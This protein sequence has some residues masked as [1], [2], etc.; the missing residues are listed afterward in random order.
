MSKPMRAKVVC[1]EVKVFEGSENVTFRPVCKQ[2][3]PY[4]A[5]GL[6]ENNTFAKYSPSGEFSLLIANP[7]LLGVYK[8]GQAFYVD[9]TP[10]TL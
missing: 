2:D 9:F 5:D 3:G 7:A 10:T 6:D 4:P 8:P 1:R